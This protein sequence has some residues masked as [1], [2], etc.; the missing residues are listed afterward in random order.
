MNPRRKSG[1]YNSVSP[2]QGVSIGSGAGFPN[3]RIRKINQRCIV[4]AGG[5]AQQCDRIVVDSDIVSYLFQAAVDRE[6]GNRI[7]KRPV[8][9]VYKAGAHAN[10]VLL[11][12][13]HVQESG[14]GILL[15][16][17]RSG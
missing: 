1:L 14:L 12:N 16:T 13:P 17:S 3:H 5:G 7:R 11:R 10:Q 15:R 4:I 2:D 6:I 9:Q 8:A